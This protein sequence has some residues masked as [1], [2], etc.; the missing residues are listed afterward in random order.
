M[1]EETLEIKELT[2]RL[3]VSPISQGNVHTYFLDSPIGAPDTYRD[4][5]QILLNAP[6]TD[7]IRL[8]INGPGGYLD[9]AIQLC[10]L[11]QT[12]NAHVEAHILGD[13]CSAQGM[14]AL[15]CHSW[16]TY[17]SSRV[18]L[19]TYRGGLYGKAP[20]LITSL[21][22]DTVRIEAFLRDLATDFCTEEEIVDMLKNGKDIWI[23]GEDLLKRLNNLHENRMLLEKIQ[24]IELLDEQ[25]KAIEEAIKARQ[26][27]SDTSTCEQ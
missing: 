11:I 7:V 21:E 23:Q 2:P 17:P 5:S 16:I 20:E 18:M 27:G 15:A 4:L 25:R 3:S 8:M 19:H 13:A 10:N 12:S 24:E 26:E 22:S 1:D 6:E 14:I 9:T